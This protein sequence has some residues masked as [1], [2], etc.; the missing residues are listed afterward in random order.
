M[1]EDRKAIF[2]DQ[3]DYYPPRLLLEALDTAKDELSYSNYHGRLFE[4]TQ[5]LIRAYCR[6]H[7]IPLGP[8]EKQR[9]AT[10]ERRD[11]RIMAAAEAGDMTPLLKML[12]AREK[13]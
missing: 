9:K 6:E 2:I 13:L 7:K 10:R 4:M 1:S 12:E 8:T 3:G 11:A 5:R